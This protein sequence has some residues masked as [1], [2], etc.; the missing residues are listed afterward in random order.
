MY[1]RISRH[2][3]EVGHHETGLRFWEVV[4]AHLKPP[5]WWGAAPAQTAVIT[6]DPPNHGG[7]LAS[8]LSC[9]ES[10]DCAGIGGQIRW[11]M[12][13][14]GG[15]DRFRRFGSAATLSRR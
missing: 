10:A 12:M 4:L 3:K 11:A 13:G 15:R 9:R 5:L 6:Q 8:A 14:T 7:R 2:H 1:A